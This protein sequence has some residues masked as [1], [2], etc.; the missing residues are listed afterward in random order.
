LPK[1]PEINKV[2]GLFGI[3]SIIP[4]GIQNNFFIGNDFF[5]LGKLLYTSKH[6]KLAGKKEKY[7]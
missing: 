2:V 5:F 1:I 4:V 3:F 6:T 7:K